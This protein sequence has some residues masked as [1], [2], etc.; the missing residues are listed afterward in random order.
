MCKDNCHS[1]M[2]QV[3]D[4][5]G[6]RI[7]AGGTMRGGFHKPG[8]L[9]LNLCN[10]PRPLMMSEHILSREEFIKRHTDPRIDILWPDFGVP[11][12]QTQDFWTD[13]VDVIRK[14]GKDVSILCQG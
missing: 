12:F 10:L 14:T 13:L 6:I 9:L 7:F 4:D 1:G 2:L 11:P 5:D 3:F 8:T